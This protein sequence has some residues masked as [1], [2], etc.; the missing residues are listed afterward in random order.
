MKLRLGVVSLSAV[1]L[2]CA[3]AGCSSNRDG[4]VVPTSSSTGVSPSPSSTA[5]F[6]QTACTAPAVSEG[7]YSFVDTTGLVTGNTYT[8]QSG[9]WG[10]FTY[11]TPVP[12]PSSLPTVPGTPTPMPSPELPVPTPTGMVTMYYGTYSI[13][14]F[15]G[16]IVND[17]GPYTSAA[18]TGCLQLVL[19][20]RPGG[21]AGQSRM[22][23]AVQA[24]PT[25]NLNGFG[26]PNGDD[27]VYS[28]DG[29]PT[30]NMTITNLTPASGNGTF[31]FTDGA[32]AVVFGTLT[33]TGSK[34][35]D[36]G[37]MARRRASFLPRERAL[38]RHRP[39]AAA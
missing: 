26:Q 5:P 28:I 9:E 15:S 8:Q 31:S 36:V 29:G 6:G 30:T 11:A 21:A 16:T 12:T 13:P 24:T 39:G 34:T 18:T 23:D 19:V 1:A 4:S 33:I 22:R 37:T 27:V 17:G 14:A 25:P 10:V 7:N 3:F 38:P 2:A 20:Q 32:G 35:Q